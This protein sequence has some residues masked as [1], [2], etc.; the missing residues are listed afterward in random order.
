[1]EFNIQLEFEIVSFKGR[2][3]IGSNSLSVKVSPLS[4]TLRH[5]VM[6]QI[7]RMPWIIGCRN[8]NAERKEKSHTANY[9]EAERNQ[10][11]LHHLLER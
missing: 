10:T 3:I 8:I 2:Q 9:S 7:M 4:H 11:E 1:M 5:A 6:S